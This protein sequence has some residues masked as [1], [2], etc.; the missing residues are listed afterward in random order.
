MKTVALIEDS[1]LLR[2]LLE[3]DLIRAGY[4]VVTAAD[5]EEGLGLIQQYHPD[6]ILLDMLLPKVAGLEVLS[7]L[8]S[9]LSTKHIPVVVLTGLSKGNSERLRSSGAAAFY[10]KSDHTLQAGSSG[11]ISVIEEVITKQPSMQ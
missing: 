10:E 5:G 7:A 11:L 1:R 8:K 3:K 9:D 2:T 6:V 4:K